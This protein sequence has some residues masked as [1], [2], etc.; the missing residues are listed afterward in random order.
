M[1]HF[2]QWKIVSIAFVAVLGLLLTIPNFISEDDVPDWLPSYRMTLGLDLQ[3]GSHLLFEVDRAALVAEIANDL[4]EQ[5]RTALRDQR[6]AYTDLEA[7]PQGARVTVR[8]PA[9]VDA[10]ASALNEIVSTGQAITFAGAAPDIAMTRDGPTF[11]F[12]LTEDGLA[13]RLGTAVDQSIEVIRRRIDEL[14][15]TEPSI[16]RQGIDT[17]LVQVPGLD[18]PARLKALIGST[19][20]MTFQLVDVSTTAAQAGDR[21]PPGSEVLPSADGTEGGYVVEQRVMVSGE[22]LVD[23]QPGFD[24]QTGEPVVNFRFNAS[25]GRRFGLV[26]TQNVGRPFAIVLDGEVISAPV[27]RSA[28]TGGSGQISGNFTVA[29]ANDLAVLLRAGALPAPLNI[30]EER[31]V[32]PGLGADSIAAGSLAAIIGAVAVLAFMVLTY[33]LF[34]L[35]ADIALVINISLI[36]AILSALGATLTLP[37]IAGIVLTIGMAVDSNVLIFERIREEVRNGRAAISAIDVGFSKALGTIVDA[38]ITTLIAAVVLFFLGS[39]PVR[40]FSVTLAIGIVTTVFTA[41]TVTRLLV[42]LWVRRARPKAV[43]I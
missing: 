43:P 28:I 22:D 6:I 35:F 24:A 27:I 4:R 25:G 39:G 17:I 41:Y 18:D 9:E 33:G 16:Q 38:N 42:A 19:A 13:R 40:G 34:G 2:A 26:T 32:G 21:P 31:T 30:L 8:D 29:E 12:T 20:K 10:A 37:G 14:G 11:T 23:A 15:T 7:L 5:T 36:I 1:L 3:G